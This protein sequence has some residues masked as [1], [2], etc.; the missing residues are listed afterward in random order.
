MTDYSDV[1]HKRKAIF[2]FM[3]DGEHHCVILTKV[4]EFPKRR[5][6]LHRRTGFL[7]SG[8]IGPFYL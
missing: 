8:N 4:Y 1:T 5:S 2:G 3:E 7:L 6:G